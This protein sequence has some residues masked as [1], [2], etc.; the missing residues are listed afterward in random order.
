M[1]SEVLFPQLDWLVDSPRL[2]I[3][4]RSGKKL[5][6]RRVELDQDTFDVFRQICTSAI[7]R[8][9]ADVT[10]AREYQAFGTLEANQIFYIQ[11]NAA[12]AADVDAAS[13]VVL[14][15]G[16]DEL[17][18]ADVEEEKKLAFY[19]IVWGSDDH[20]VGF[21]RKAD[22]RSTISKNKHFFSW[23]NALKH[24]E[25]PDFILDPEIDL[26][27]GGLTA[28]ILNE[29]NSRVLMN[30]VGL[31]MSQADENVDKLIGILGG[32]AALTD[33]ARMALLTAASSSVS[34]ARRLS[35][36][37]AYYSGRT[38]DSARIREQAI[39]QF[40]NDADVL[41][42]ADGRLCAEGSRLNDAL[43]VIEGR[44]FRDPISEEDRRADRLS[45]RP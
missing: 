27:V 4:W 17:L 9:N 11:P 19:A 18:K 45:K 15:N 25:S 7:E 24:V 43:D 28:I 35:K 14:V 5:E 29:P 39:A 30:D 16:A 36:F 22:P 20:R 13:I 34:M 32:D 41:F 38:L 40:G 42:N 12:H 21:V 2:V 3:G 6:A 1:D 10:E 26:V 37:S 44:L 8:I 23:D 33:E 31:A